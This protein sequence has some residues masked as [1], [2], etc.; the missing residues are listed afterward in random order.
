[1]AFYQGLQDFFYR[2]TAANEERP[3]GVCSIRF[4]LPERSEGEQAFTA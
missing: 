2:F 1:M 4:V 3:K